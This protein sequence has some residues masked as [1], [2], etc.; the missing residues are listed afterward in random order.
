M[1][2]AFVIIRDDVSE[3]LVARSYARHKTMGCPTLYE[4]FA[5]LGITLGSS[6]VKE[7]V[8]TGGR[9]YILPNDC[10][11]L[12]IGQTEELVRACKVADEDDEDRDISFIRAE[13]YR[14]H[15]RY[16]RIQVHPI[17]RQTDTLIA[18]GAEARLPEPS[19]DGWHELDWWP[20]S[21]YFVITEDYPSPIGD[22]RLSLPVHIK[23][24][25]K[26]DGKK[27]IDA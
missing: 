1:A 23:W 12:M 10:V 11:L 6:K 13:S 2:A 8:I 20:L 27:W 25:D 21:S 5:R 3:A 17:S 24:I 26:N 14:L 16:A 22:Y 9:T 19:K 18:L 4:A 7:E 15:L